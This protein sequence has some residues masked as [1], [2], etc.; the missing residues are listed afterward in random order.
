MKIDDKI[1]DE[2]LQYDINREAAKILALSFGKIDKYEYLTSKEIIP[3]YQ[4][5]VSLHILL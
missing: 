2:I 5:R 1:K 3:I 4:R